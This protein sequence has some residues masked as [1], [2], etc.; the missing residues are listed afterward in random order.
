MTDHDYFTVSRTNAKPHKE[1]GKIGIHFSDA[2]RHN[3]EKGTTSYSMIWPGL[4]VT[5]CVSDPEGFANAVAQVL[6]ENAD[7]FFKSAQQDGSND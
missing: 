3:P 1:G 4:L 6:N 2:P 5:E 7:R